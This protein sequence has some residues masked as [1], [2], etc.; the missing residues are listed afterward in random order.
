[1]RTNGVKISILQLFIRAILG[2]YTFEI[3][4]PVFAVIL[5]VF[6]NM[7]LFG[8]VVLAALPIIQAVCLLVTRNTRQAL[9]DLLSDT[10]T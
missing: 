3:M 8:V 5:V 10:V 6:A 4:L 7:A 2:K 1:M 9:H